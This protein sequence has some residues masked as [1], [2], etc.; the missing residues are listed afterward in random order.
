MRAARVWWTGGGDRG[1]IIQPGQMGPGQLTD[2]ILKRNAPLHIWTPARLFSPDI[3]AESAAPPR[4]L[5]LLQ[6]RGKEDRRRGR[7]AETCTATG[8]QSATDSESHRGFR[9]RAAIR[10][11]KAG[12]RDAADVFISKQKNKK[13]KKTDPGL[14]TESSAAFC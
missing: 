12:G 2:G 4:E 14:R 10:G 9:R 1:L 13:Y 11:N 5:H 3:S 6:K 7:E 8:A